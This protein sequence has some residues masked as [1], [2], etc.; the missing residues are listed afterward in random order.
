M[1]PVARVSARPPSSPPGLTRW[2]ILKRSERGRTEGLSELQLSMDCRVKPG[3][4]ELENVLATHI[5]PSFTDRYDVKREERAVRSEKK[6]WCLVFLNPPALASPKYSFEHDL[7]RKPVPT[8]RDHALKNERIWNADR[9]S[10]QPAALLARPRLQ[11]E[12]HAYRRSTTA[13]PLGLFIAKVQLQAMLPGTWRSADPVVVPIPGQNRHSLCGCYPPQ[14][15]VP[16]QRAPR[17]L[18]CSARR[19]MPEAARVRFAIPP[20]GTALAPVPRY[21][22]ATGP[23]T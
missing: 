16:V 20:A 17:G 4:D 1:A 7:I 11:Q 5:R 8:F 15:P 18:V 3:N 22:F 9:R 19:L 10:I 2:S 14:K 13:L 23:F 12:A 21:A 6:G